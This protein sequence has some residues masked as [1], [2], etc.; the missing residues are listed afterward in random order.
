MMKVL[1]INVSF[2]DFFITI[3]ICVVEVIVDSEKA[4]GHSKLQIV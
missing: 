4:R 3:L 2:V 1:F